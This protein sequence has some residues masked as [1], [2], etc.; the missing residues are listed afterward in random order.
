MGNFRKGTRIPDD[1]II[2]ARN[3]DTKE[4]I[5]HRTGYTFQRAGSEWHCKEHDSLVVFSDGKGWHWYSRGESGATAIDWMIKIEGFGFQDAVSELVG[6]P[7]NR[8]YNVLDSSTVKQKPKELVLPPK[9]NTL[10][11]VFAYLCSTRKITPEVVEW[12]VKND[13]LY[14]DDHNNAVFVGKDSSGKPRFATR[15]GTYS[16]DGAPAFKKDCI[17]SSKSY[18]FVMQGSCETHIYVFEAA[19]DA[20]SHAS[21]GQLKGMA[22]GRTDYK[23]AWQ[24]H[25]R[26]A[27]G[28][29]SDNALKFYLTEHPQIK[30]ISFCLDNDEAGEKAAKEYCEKYSKQGYVTHAYFAPKQVGKDYNEFLQAFT[31][32]LESKGLLNNKGAKSNMQSNGRKK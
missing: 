10:R 32:V 3:M 17:G 22:I 21:L 27:L 11:N 23:T 2:A 16:F 13:I 24:A 18:G 31:G 19:I 4:V 9:A 12:C 15:R 20:M 1:D 25:T 29:V 5:S 8:N 14:Q 30:E 28:G 7:L 6:N 26:L